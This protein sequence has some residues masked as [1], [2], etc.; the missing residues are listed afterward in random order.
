MQRNNA[1]N[2]GTWAMLLFAIAICVAI[3]NFRPII[4][5]LGHKTTTGT[6]TQK[7]PSNHLGLGFSYQVNGR[8]FEGN[9]YAGQI[10]RAF[11]DI[12]LGDEVT[13]FYAE[14]SPATS[15]L[16]NPHVLVVRSVGQIIAASLIFSLL[17]MCVLHRYR[18]LPECSIFQKC[19]GQN[20]EN[21]NG[22]V[23]PKR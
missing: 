19:R 15:T 20:L 16:E 10:N 9:G 11:Q 13:V 4:L 1:I 8:T 2:L 6:I 17:G 21:K 23:P 14:R 3:F 5:W 18:L 12:H 22:G 7:F